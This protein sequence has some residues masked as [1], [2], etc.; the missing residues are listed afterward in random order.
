MNDGCTLK[1]VLHDKLV[2]GARPIGRPYLSYKDTCE[3]DVTITGIDINKWETAA[4][5]SDM[6]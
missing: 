4:S 3:C 1:D 5:D 2:I 6:A